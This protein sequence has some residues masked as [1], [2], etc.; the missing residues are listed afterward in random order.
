MKKVFKF[1]VSILF[2]LAAGFFGS[3]FT[4][5]S[6]P[7]W[8]AALNKPFFTP[9]N[10]LFAPAWTTLFILMGIALFLVWIKGFKK[11]E[12]K[13]AMLFFLIQLILNVAWSFYFFYWK[14][15]FWALID[16]IILWFFILLTLIQ[17][18]KINKTA[19]ALLIPYLLW[20]SFA[21]LLNY[22]VWKLN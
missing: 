11:K 8:Y 7:T 16:I 20:V 12:V 1:F 3:I 5:P 9:P 17:F 19:G 2:C 21:S 18:W 22:S 4:T 13:G 14:T 10:W 15:P 6:I